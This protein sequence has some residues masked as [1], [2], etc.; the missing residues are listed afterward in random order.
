MCAHID[1][2]TVFTQINESYSGYQS[3]ANFAEE[4]GGNGWRKERGEEKR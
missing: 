1:V 3:L 4:T 2:P